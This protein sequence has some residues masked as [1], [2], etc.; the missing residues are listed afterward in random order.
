[1][2][3]LPWIF[4]KSKRTLKKSNCHILKTL[5]FT[6]K[7]F[8]KFDFFSSSILV[9]LNYQLFVDVFVCMLLVLVC[10]L[11]Y[12]SVLFCIQQ[13]PK[14]FIITL[15]N[16]SLG[17][18]IGTRSAIVCNITK[19]KLEFRLLKQWDFIGIVVFSANGLTLFAL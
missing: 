18:K 1:M 5:L 2:N 12:N 7:P 19:G 9:L 14:N 13:G 3:I 10:Y 15:K 17:A 8:E 6:W 11:F 16:P 4:L